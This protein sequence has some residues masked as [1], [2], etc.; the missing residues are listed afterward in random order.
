LSTF[1]GILFCKL[2]LNP[3]NGKVKE[4]AAEEDSRMELIQDGI[5]GIHD[6]EHPRAIR[7]KLE[8]HS[9]ART[10][11]NQISPEPEVVLP[12]KKVALDRRIEPVLP[13]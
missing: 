1:Y 7:F 8:N 12:S 4:F 9:A 10:A 13:R 3:L 6:R 2:G 11:F 5:L